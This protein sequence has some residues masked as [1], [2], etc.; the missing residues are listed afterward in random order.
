[1]TLLAPSSLRERQF[2]AAMPATPMKNGS[3][4]GASLMAGNSTMSALEK[5]ARLALDN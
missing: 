5:L 1:M 3:M 2:G 4:V